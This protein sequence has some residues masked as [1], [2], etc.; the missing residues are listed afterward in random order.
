MEDNLLFRIR[1]YLLRILIA[2]NQ[3]VGVTFFGFFYLIGLANRPN[4]DE[5]ISSRVG[6]AA[7]QGHKVALIAE[8]V[9]NFLFLPFEKNHCR[10]RIEHDEIN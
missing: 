7:I 8:K 2:I 5:T 6:R 9:I 4:A 3:L 10:K 1:Y